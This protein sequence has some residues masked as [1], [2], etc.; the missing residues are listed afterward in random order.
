MKFSI[1]REINES[2]SFLDVE[3]F[4]ENKSLLLVTA[5]Y[6]HATHVFQSESTLYSCLNELNAC[7]LQT[8]WLLVRI[9]LL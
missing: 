3:I 7:T 2:L 8:K 6:Y 4:R 5:C 1:E 9:S